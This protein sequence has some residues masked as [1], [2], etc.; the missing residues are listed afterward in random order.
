[1]SLGVVD[2]H[3]DGIE[4]HRLGVDQPDEELRRVK[5]LQEGGLIGRPCEC[6]GVT[7]GEPER[8]ESRDLA[9]QLFGHRLGHARLAQAALDE[10]PVELLHLPG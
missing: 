2:Q 10:L 3:L 1:M 8:G 4:A 5:K 7:L 6:R 9:E